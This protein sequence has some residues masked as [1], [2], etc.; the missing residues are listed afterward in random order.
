MLIAIHQPN[1]FPWL[2]YFEKIKRG[3][4]FVILNNVQRPKKGASWSNRVQFNEQGGPKWLTAPISKEKSKS[5]LINETY[6][7]DTDWKEKMKITIQRNYGKSPLF[8]DYYEEICKLIDFQ[9]NNMAEY[10]INCIKGLCKLLKI[11]FNDK[12]ILS[13]EL[14]ISSN[15]TQKLIDITKAVNG[16]ACMVGGGTDGYLDQEVFK[17]NNIKLVYQ[18]FKMIPYKQI[19]TKTFLPGLSVMDFIFN[20]G[21]D[22]DPY[23]QADK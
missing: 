22:I 5:L 23:L 17:Q 10:N 19:K 20:C 8:K 1:F 14:N 6:F 12:F 11:D 4:K 16:N 2:G 13:A 21:L 3:D 18:K 9:S 7:Q 15:S